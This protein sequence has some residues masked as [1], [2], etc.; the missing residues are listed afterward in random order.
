MKRYVKESVIK[1]ADGEELLVVEVTESKPKK[2]AFII[3]ERK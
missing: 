1:N 3:W 2:V